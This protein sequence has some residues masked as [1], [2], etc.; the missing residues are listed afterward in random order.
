MSFTYEAGS[1]GI[2]PGMKKKIQRRALHPSFS[3]HQR[4]VLRVFKAQVGDRGSSAQFAHKLTW[5]RYSE[6]LN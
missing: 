5:P 6:T 2:N 1:P 3:F 4:F